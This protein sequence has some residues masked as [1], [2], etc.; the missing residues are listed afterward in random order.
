MGAL[1]FFGACLIILLD[2]FIA[3]EFYDIATQKGFDERKYFW[4]CFFVSVIGYA[5]VIALPDHSNAK[6]G[7]AVDELPEL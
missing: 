1:R 6:T 2:W 7:I 4:W 5:M 3:E